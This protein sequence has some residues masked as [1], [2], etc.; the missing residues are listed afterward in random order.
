MQNICLNEPE[1]SGNSLADD[2]FE[3]ETRGVSAT[4]RRRIEAW[5]RTP[6]KIARVD[7]SRSIILPHPDRP[8]WVLKIKGAGFKGGPIRFGTRLRTG[9]AA[10]VFD[11]EG[12]RMADIASGHDNAD[13]GAASFQQAAV[14]YTL[15]RRLQD[16][17][18]PVVPCIGYGRVS[19]GAHVTWFSV[20]ELD[21]TYGPTGDYVQ[22]N[23]HNTR[24]LLDL[25]TRHSL[26]GYFWFE[27]G[28]DGTFFLKDLHPFH[29]MDPINHSQLSW[30]LQVCDAL[31]T[32]CQACRHFG[33]GMVAETD[34]A[35]LGALALRG[36][37]PDAG[38][39]DYLD[40]RHRVVKPYVQS[41]PEDFSVSGL[42]ADLKSTR[43]G[44]SLLDLCPEPYARWH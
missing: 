17:G 3:I 28:A 31:Y 36:L 42:Y 23:L 27:R 37:L 14:E 2:L 18:Y 19:H 6:S 40:L 10:Q 39:S 24:M 35:S 1:I 25:A 4:V 12:R 20:F 16:L 43:V 7:G 5:F 34:P 33:Q 38:P 26:V 13:L 29:A 41:S 22:S 30:T 15:T 11:F 8:G 44:A 32:R 9:P 21:K